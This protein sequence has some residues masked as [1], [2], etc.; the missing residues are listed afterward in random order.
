MGGFRHGNAQPEFEI[1][2]SEEQRVD[3]FDGG[4]GFGIGH[5]FGCFDLGKEQRVRIGRCGVVPAFAVNHAPAA[6]GAFTQGG[7]PGRVDDLRGLPGRVNHG[8]HDAGGPHIEY[9]SDGAVFVRRYPRDAAQAEA[10]ARADAFEE[11]AVAELAVL[12]VE[13]DP[14]PAAS[15][16][17]D[18]ARAGETH[19]ESDLDLS[20][21]K[22]AHEI[23]C[24]WG[25]SLVIGGLAG[26]G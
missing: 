15:D 22:P 19:G 2:G 4:N 26:A 5:S 21:P 18:S 1:L 24:H 16:E 9:A 11:I 23:R 3:P 13:P 25:F 8:N 17:F 10:I 12:A 6:E 14:V 7:E 20:F